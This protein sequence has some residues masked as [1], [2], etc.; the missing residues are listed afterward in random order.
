[1]SR[2]RMLGFKDRI[3]L[4]IHNRLFFLN[5]L[6]IVSKIGFRYQSTTNEWLHPK[7]LQFQ[8]SDF[9]INPQPIMA[10]SQSWISFKD[11]I[12]LSIHNFLCL[13][14]LSFDVS[15]IGFRYQSTTEINVILNKAWFQR[16]DFVIN[17]QL[18]WTRKQQNKC[19]KDRISLSI[20]NFRFVRGE[21]N[22][23]S[24]IGFRYQSTTRLLDFDRLH[25]FKDRISL[26]IH[27]GKRKSV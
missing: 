22:F 21:S 11:R 8:R 18:R 3:S 6:L 15:K 25:S 24:K 26:S 2:I 23:V 14:S 9:V 13:L 7:R 27:N 4:S 20:H 5:S 19:F 16:S 17:P 1:M 12:S 10:D